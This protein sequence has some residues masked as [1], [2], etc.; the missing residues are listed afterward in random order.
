[1]FT[2]LD[3]TVYYG[4]FFFFQS[5]GLP[6]TPL[7]MIKPISAGLCPVLPSSQAPRYVYS[8]HLWQLDLFTI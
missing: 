5:S 3:V 4:L 1:M 7:S 6:L 8:L 2:I